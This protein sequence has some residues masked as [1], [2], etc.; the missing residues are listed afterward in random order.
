[1]TETVQDGRAG[2]TTAGGAAEPAPSGRDTAL[3]GP[4]A[5]QDR[6]RAGARRG[7]VG[8]GLVLL[9]G[10]VG[11][12]AA[13]LPVPRIE[14]WLLAVAAVLGLSLVVLVLALLPST[15]GRTATGDGSTKD[16]ALTPLPG[17]APHPA[18][19]E[20]GSRAPGTGSG[21]GPTAGGSAPDAAPHP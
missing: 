17:D 16:G 11:T 20:D 8:T 1:M 10:V 6:A 21:R 7:T 15:R 12:A 18:A 19:A 13:V 3:S 9:L 2:M 4:G 5:A 14:L